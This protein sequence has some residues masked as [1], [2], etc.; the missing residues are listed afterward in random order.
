MPVV[1]KAALRAVGFPGITVPALKIDGRKVQGSREIA[2]ELDRIKPEPP[3]L[4]ADPTRPGGRRAGR[5]LGR[6]GAPARGPPDPVE[7]AAAR[8]RP[9]RLLLGGRP[10][11]RPGGAR[12]E[13]RGQP[14]V[15]LSARLNEA[16]VDNVRA[17]LAAL[18]GMLQRIDD[19]IADG[20]LGSEHLNAADLQ[21]ATSV[22]VADDP[23]GPP[24]H[25]RL[26]AR[27]PARDARGVGL[28]RPTRRRSCRPRGSSRCGLRARPELA[29]AGH[30]LAVAQRGERLAQPRSVGQRRAPDRAPAE[31]RA[32]TAAR[33]PAGAAGSAAPSA[34]RARPAAAGRRRAGAGRGA[35]RRASRPRSASIALQAS[36]SSSGPRSVSIATAAFRKS[37]WSRI[38]PTGS[39]S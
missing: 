5:D 6:R 39:V 20:T 18:P 31:A 38:S 12:R 34:A 1:S 35:G 36:S 7:R 26:L 23:S 30:A 32:R 13:D 2:R 19:W 21:I 25:D 8:A 24:R 14:L 16:T 17:D 4:P 3:L 28:R 27:G 29:D 33:S 37:G 22:A 9:A 15:A 11:G 10:S